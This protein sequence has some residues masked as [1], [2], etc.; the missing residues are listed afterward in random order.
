MNKI[1]K[2]ISLAVVLSIGAT[3]CYKDLNQTPP[4]DVT[5][6]S[7]FKDFKNY[8]NIVAKLYGGL[9]LTGQQGPDGA[10]DIYSPDE[11]F[12]SYLRAFWTLQQLPTDESKCSW[13][14]DG[15]PDISK[16]TWAASNQFVFYPY[17]RIY[18]QISQA[19]SF[20]RETTDAKLTS[21]QITGTNEIE[22]KLFRDEARFLRA[23]SYAHALDLYRNVPLVKD[24]DPVGE[25]PRQ[26]T[27]QEVFDYIESEL[28]DI[29]NTLPAAR[30]N[31]YGRADKGAVWMLLARLYLN[32]QVYTGTARYADALAYSKKVIDAGY[33]LDKKYKDVFAADN[34]SSTENIFTINSDGNRTR[35]WGGTTFLS[36]A[37]V[38]NKMVAASYGLDGGWRGIRSTKAFVKK[39]MDTS[40]NLVADGRALFFTTDQSIESTEFTEFKYG[41]ATT[42][43]SN[44]KKDGTPGSNPTWVDNDFPLFRLADAYL[45]YAESALRGGGG[46]LS[47][48]TSYVNLL[49]ERAYGNTSGNITQADLTLPF[50]IDERSREL[51]QEGVRR[52]DLVRFGLFTGSEYIWPWKGNKL[53]GASLDAF[54]AIF[55]IPVQDLASNKNLKQN[56]GY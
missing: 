14:N 17:N 22:A 31:E 33:V 51:Y 27:A 4:Y 5:S 49:R 39:F 34:Q 1:I 35:T 30:T 46:S 40:G 52:T 43:W 50:I 9:L 41:Y 32:A 11:G 12:S 21:N 6:A 47:D 3:S 13:T 42:K 20:I 37:H 56:T 2:G 45:M 8:K 18:F 54:K 36:H 53:E 15:L 48:A 55:P 16:G 19:N 29:E 44:L 38:G 28:K 24:T 7:L 25:S 23:L 26:G 10:A